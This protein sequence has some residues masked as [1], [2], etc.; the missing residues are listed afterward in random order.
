MG[1]LDGLVGRGTGQL[2]E[3]VGGLLG[4]ESPVGG[5]NGLLGKLDAQGLTELGASWIGT[6][7]NLPISAAQIEKVL[8]NDAIAGVAAKLGITP[9]KASSQLAT[10]LPKIVDQISPD[11]KVPDAASL[12]KALGG[13]LKR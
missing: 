1:F 9:E 11:G 5:L 3:A 4:G 2:T 12:Q 6:G 13:L 8:G 10:L 7:K